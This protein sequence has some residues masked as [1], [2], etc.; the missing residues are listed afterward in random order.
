MH[1]GHVSTVNPTTMHVRKRDGSL[2]PVDLNKILHA[3]ATHCSGL[4]SVNPMQV[5]IKTVGGLHEGATTRELDALAVHTAAGLIGED[6]EYSQLAARLLSASV[7]KDVEVQNIYSFSQ[8][9]QAAQEQGMIHPRLSAFVK[10]HALKLN[11]AIDPTRDREFEFFGLKTF[12]DRYVLLH[13]K[14]RLPL[15]TPQYAWMRVAAALCKGRIQAAL[16]LYALL[17]KLEYLPGS[18]TLFNAG[19][20]NEQLSSCF[21]LDSPADELLDIYRLYSDVAALSKFSGGIG[22]SFS[23][24]RSRGSLIRSTNGFSAGIVPWL[25]TLDASVAAVQQG[26]KRRGACA[27]YMEPWHADIEDFL[28]LRDNTGDEARRTRNLNLANWLPDLFMER[29]KRD[30]DWSLFDPKDVPEL[31]DTFGKRFREAYEDA[32]RR[33][34]A[35][36]VLPARKLYQ[37]MLRTLAET[38]VG[39]MTFKDRANVLCNQT[40]EHRHVVHSSNLC[41]EIFEVSGTTETAVCN[42]GSI[43]LARLVDT[44]DMYE[45]LRRIV[46]VAVTQ[47]DAVID[48]NA[49][50]TA[51]TAASNNRWRPIGLGV[52]GLQ[53]I[54]FRRGIAFDS[55][56]ALAL[57]TEIAAEIYVS[58]METS[59]ALAE[60]YGKFEAWGDSRTSARQWHHERATGKIH[61]IHERLRERWQT[62]VE[63]IRKHGLRNS[64]M[65]AIAPTATIASIAGCYECIEPQTSN[66][67]KRETMS[68][69]FLQV[70][71]YLTLALKDIGLWTPEIRAAIKAANGSIAGIEAIP[72]HI[73]QLYRTAWELSQRT[74]IDLAAARQPWVDQGQSLNLFVESPTIGKLS[75]M[76]MYAWEQGLKSTYY[77][78]SRP[79]TEIAKVTNTP[80]TE[81][82]AEAAVACSLENP[83]ACEACA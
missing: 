26:G 20:A 51:T 73:R 30:E 79:A 72:A 2:Q 54:F 69:D 17:S 38:G 43:N 12:V 42:L 80:V 18:P 78:R 56:E 62:L 28:E 25:R 44:D 8:S 22:V 11:A 21:L 10:E 74:L 82:A 40:L 46:R 41:T 71:K 6:P 34:L 7:R 24:I 52:M 64:L 68:G 14:T 58:A 77:L 60:A 83:E 55:P 37:R 76:Y 19:T 5:A 39:W 53:D 65:I 29:V 31:V 47:L 3:V 50:Q 35:K 36:K 67:F 32:E 66:L 9:V 23:R 61:Q 13:P 59:C 70:N 45:Q 33:D 4:T 75:S 48:I 57:S 16:D 27:V 49:Y 63:R 81:A 1:D 15:E